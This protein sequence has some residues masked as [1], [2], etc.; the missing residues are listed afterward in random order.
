MSDAKAGFRQSA[1]LHCGII[2][3]AQPVWHNQPAMWQCNII[4]TRCD[5]L[6]LLF[7]CIATEHYQK[8]AWRCIASSLSGMAVERPCPN[9]MTLRGG[10]PEHYLCPFC[11]VNVLFFACVFPRRSF[12]L[13]AMQSERRC[14]HVPA[15][16]GQTAVHSARHLSGSSL[17]RSEPLF[18][19]GLGFQLFFMF[20]R[21]FNSF[22]F[23]RTF[24]LYV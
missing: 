10:H 19:W 12:Y 6:T 11:R 3:R 18:C 14:F 16:T 17:P 7:T 23:L 8:P 4:S 5:S 22:Y 2:A 1:F 20:F 9:C 24:F 13:T 15:R 21:V